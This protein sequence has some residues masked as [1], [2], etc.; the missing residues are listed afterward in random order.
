MIV[1]YNGYQVSDAAIR[2]CL[3]RIADATGRV[4]TVT[5]GDKDF[6]PSGGAKNSDHLHK[7]AADFHLEGLTDEVA[8]DEVRSK[9]SAIFSEPMIFQ[10][11]RHGPHTQ[12]QG[13]HIHLGEPAAGSPRCGFWTEGLTPSTKG[14]YRKIG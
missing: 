3:E 1:K 10:V 6:V 12:T 9:R 13:P 4:I 8:F 5:S 11:I 14:H 2:A 7:R